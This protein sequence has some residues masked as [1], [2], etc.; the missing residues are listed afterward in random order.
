MI[1]ANFLA[2]YL[3]FW[4]ALGDVLGLDV[5]LGLGHHPTDLLSLSVDDLVEADLL[6][7]DLAVGVLVGHIVLAVLGLANCKHAMT[8]SWSVLV[9]LRAPLFST[10]TARFDYIQP[11]KRKI[12]GNP[13]DK[14]A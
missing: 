10:D 13:I 12:V 8:G 14:M 11:R 9:F 2:H 6:G 4:E 7:H 5:A 3:S 1:L